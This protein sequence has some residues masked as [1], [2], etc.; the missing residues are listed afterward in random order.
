MFL[1]VLF[2]LE[3]FPASVRWSV[4]L[5]LAVLAYLSIKVYPA[6][7]LVESVRC[8]LGTSLSEPETQEVGVMLRMR[9][10]QGGQAQPP[11]VAPG[12]SKALELFGHIPL[13]ATSCLAEEKQTTQIQRIRFR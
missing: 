7:L 13:V 1:D 2:D 3:P 8:H 4:I 12:V 10:E 6:T 9:G 5:W 11:A